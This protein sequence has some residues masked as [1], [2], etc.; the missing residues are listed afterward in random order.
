MSTQDFLHRL[1][2]NCNEIMLVKTEDL[3]SKCHRLNKRQRYN[4]CDDENVVMMM[5]TWAGVQ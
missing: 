3:K 1:I 4:D 2:V 5:R